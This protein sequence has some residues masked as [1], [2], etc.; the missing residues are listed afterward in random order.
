M[1]NKIHPAI[2]ARLVYYIIEPWNS[3]WDNRREGK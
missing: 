1:I 2:F 3:Y